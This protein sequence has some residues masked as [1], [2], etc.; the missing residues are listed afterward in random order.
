MA[1]LFNADEIAH[2]TIPVGVGA[3]G[4]AVAENRVITASDDPRLLFPDSEIN[5]RFFDGTGFRSMI[6]APV[7]GEAGPLGALEV[8]AVRPAAFDDDDA[9]RKATDR[10]ANILRGEMSAVGPRPL[11]AAD[12]ARLDQMLDAEIS[13]YH[14]LAA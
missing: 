1:H 6:V 10:V 7:D 13:L 2:M 11:T 3:T 4:L 8:Y 14:E 5:D 9:G 12:V